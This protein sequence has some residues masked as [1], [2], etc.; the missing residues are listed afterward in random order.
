MLQS[1]CEMMGLPAPTDEVKPRLSRLDRLTPGDFALV[2]RQHGF[3]PLESVV[4]MVEAL[5][6]ECKFKGGSTPIGFVNR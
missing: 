3:R 1:Y 4:E 5:G 6:V 2:A